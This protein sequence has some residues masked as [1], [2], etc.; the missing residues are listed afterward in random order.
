LEYF[1]TLSW[2]SLFGNEEYFL[3]TG[4]SFL[5]SQNSPPSIYFPPPQAEEVRHSRRRVCS[6]LPLHQRRS[7]PHLAFLFC[8]IQHFLARGSFFFFLPLKARYRSPPLSADPE[9]DFPPMLRV[10]QRAFSAAAVF[11]GSP[12]T[13]P[14]RDLFLEQQRSPLPFVIQSTAVPRCPSRNRLPLWHR[15]IP[16]LSC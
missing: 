3:D 16:F 13:P 10:T 9:H 7:S 8:N 14:G 12:I 11:L 5:L 15:T 4:E 2:A 6:L 1:L